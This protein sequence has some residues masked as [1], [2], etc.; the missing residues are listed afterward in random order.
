MDVLQ[1]SPINVRGRPHLKLLNICSPFEKQKQTC[2]TR[3]IT[4][5]RQFFKIINF[6]IGPLRV[7]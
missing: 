1:L 3:N 7:P 5:E 6:C 4:S 2:N